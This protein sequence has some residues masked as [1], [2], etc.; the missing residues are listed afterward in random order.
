MTKSIKK[1]GKKIPKKLKTTD[2]IEALKPNFNNFYFDILLNEIIFNDCKE[3]CL[4]KITK[5]ELK[6]FIIYL[7]TLK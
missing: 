3:S 4:N 6:Q 5:N 7:I 1:R 2:W